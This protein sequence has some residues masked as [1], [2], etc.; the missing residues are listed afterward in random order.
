MAMQDPGV[1]PLVEFA[2]HKNEGLGAMCESSGFRLVRRQRVTEEVVELE[3]SPV[4]QRVGLCRWILFKL[5]DLGA[6]QSHRLVSPRGWIGW[7]IVGLLRPFVAYRCLVLVA[8]KDTYWHQL[9]ARCRLR[10]R[11]GRL[12]EASWDVIEFEAV[13]FVLQPLDFLAVR[14]HLGVMIA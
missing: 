2:L 12:I 9:S 3:C 10:K 6:G 11:I 14:S 8:G 7:T 1:A 4:D 13:E 5:Y